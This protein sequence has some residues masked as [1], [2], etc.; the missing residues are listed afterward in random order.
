LQDDTRSDDYSFTITFDEAAT[1]EVHGLTSSRFFRNL[2]GVFS[3]GDDLRNLIFGYVIPTRISLTF[4][5]FWELA[6]SV[7]VNLLV[8]VV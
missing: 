1:V 6:K 8:S 2:C 4:K 5:W 3:W 7:P